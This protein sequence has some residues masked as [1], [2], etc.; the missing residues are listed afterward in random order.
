MV[1]DTRHRQFFLQRMVKDLPARERKADAVAAR[2]PAYSGSG[3]SSD[4]ELARILKEQ[5][6]VLV[7]NLI[8]PD[9]LSEMAAYFSEQEC[10]DP[11]RPRV[12]SFKPS[13]GAPAGTHVAFFT[14]EVVAHAPHVFG[15]ANDPSVLAIVAS[16]LGAKPT[17][18]YMTA[19]WSLPAGDGTAQHAEKFH[20]D[21]DDWRFVKL[22]CYLTD[23]DETAGP[24]VFVRGSHKVNK[25]T[26]IRR[27]SDE[28]VSSMFGARDIISFTGPA[29]TCFLEN[30]NGIHRGIPPVDKP[31]LIFQVLY[32]LRPVI[33]G[34]KVPVAKLGA[35]GVP[36]D[37][38]PY[39]NRVYCAAQ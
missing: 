29:G 14:N 30:T 4:A 31:R 2:L 19:W 15:V 32:S 7:P 27:F 38:D 3:N 9:P 12:G 39:V 34:P 1:T 21:V 35:N 11:Y 13:G 5:G 33:Y 25:L 23:V 26:E 16:M 36:A 6:Y 24:H 22:F 20:R 18:S 37:L 10:S 28:E 8:R 17:I